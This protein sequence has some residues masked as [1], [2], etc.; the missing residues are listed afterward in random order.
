M[1][2]MPGAAR[3]Y[4]DAIIFLRRSVGQ[5]LRYLREHLEGPMEENREAKAR[6]LAE[7]GRGRGRLGELL[8]EPIPRAVVN[9]SVQ[10]GIAYKDWATR[11]RRAIGS[12]RH[13]EA[14]LTAVRLLIREHA[15]FGGS[16]E[17]GVQAGAGATAG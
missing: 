10:L 15:G 5:R 13:T 17:S 6:M 7:L 14:D 2:E 12:G 3:A 16:H 8:R 11:A 1:T 4:D 9:G